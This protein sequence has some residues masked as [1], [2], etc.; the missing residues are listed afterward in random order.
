MSFGSIH[1]VRSHS[2]HMATI[3][4]WAERVF[5]LSSNEPGEQSYFGHPRPFECVM[6]EANENFDALI[7]FD[8]LSS[9]NFRFDRDEQMFSLILSP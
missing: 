9:Y 2:K 4:F 1:G 8:I 5:D 7:G 3:G 6:M